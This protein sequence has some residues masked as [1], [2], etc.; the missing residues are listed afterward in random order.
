[1]RE[2]LYLPCSVSLNGV[3]NPRAPESSYSRKLNPLAYGV[4]CPPHAC[5]IRG[6]GQNPPRDQLRTFRR[7]NIKLM[8]RS[9][10][11]VAGGWAKREFWDRAISGSRTKGILNDGCRLEGLL[12]DVV[13]ISYTPRQ[14]FTA[15]IAK[16]RFTQVGGQVTM[17]ACIY[18]RLYSGQNSR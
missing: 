12:V 7:R 14:G 13:C 9:S 17:K 1:V 15:A 11:F 3:H 8:V 2:S 6:L 4:Q 16:V 18:L 10:T 5:I